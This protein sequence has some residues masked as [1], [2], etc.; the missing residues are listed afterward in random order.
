MCKTSSRAICS[1][2]SL[3]A[4]K[5]E[6]ELPQT[7][8]N[9]LSAIAHK[10]SQAMARTPDSDADLGAD[11]DLYEAAAIYVQAY[12]RCKGLIISTDSSLAGALGDEPLARRPSNTAW[13]RSISSSAEKK[14]P[15]KRIAHEDSD[16]LPEGEG[17]SNEGDD[18][19][20]SP[21]LKRRR[22]NDTKLAKADKGGSPIASHQMEGEALLATN[23][24]LQDGSL[25]V[26]FLEPLPMPGIVPS[27]L[28]GPSHRPFVNNVKRDP[29]IRYW[30]NATGE[31]TA[32][33]ERR[34]RIAEIQCVLPMVL[35]IQV[36]ERWRA[37]EGGG[38]W[39]MRGKVHVG[40]ARE[41]GE[42]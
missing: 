33:R 36:V 19:D 23:D 27:S 1:K 5:R 35:C 6:N 38:G 21:S 8:P 7:R 2:N 28:Q 42:A 9:K 25:E 30:S 34:W 26:F 32:E 39:K 24:T 16:D 14:S 29:C 12:R 41:D 10:A 3:L 18:D 22:V 17:C 13:D 31:W 20:H 37:D 15:M 40:T 4:A 11:I